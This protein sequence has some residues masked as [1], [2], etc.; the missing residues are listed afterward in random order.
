[1]LR[2]APSPPPTPPVVPPHLASV[3]VRASWLP[4]A[5]AGEQGWHVVPRPPRARQHD[6]PHIEVVR[7][8]PAAAAG[9]WGTRGP[10][11]RGGSWV[12]APAGEP[13]MCGAR[14]QA[15]HPQVRVPLAQASAAAAAALPNRWSRRTGWWGCRSC[16]RTPPASAASPAPPP[17]LAPPAGATGTAGVQGGDG[18]GGA[19]G[20]LERT[21]RRSAAAAAAACCKPRVP[22]HTGWSRPTRVCIPL[23]PQRPQ[24]SDRQPPPARRRRPAS[25]Q[26]QATPLGSPRSCCTGACWSS[27]PE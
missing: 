24:R 27:P 1:M 25:A 10:C 19:A 22:Q 6:E 18:R 7:S 2:F 26:R 23:R 17:G 3:R 8:R 4:A 9:A 11:L 15:L 14:V 5:R 21:A 16:A 20:L 13:G 12:A